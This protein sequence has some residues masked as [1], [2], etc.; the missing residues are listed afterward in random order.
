MG[1]S[2]GREAL[3]AQGGTPGEQGH[4]EPLGRPLHLSHH[5]KDGSV[6]PHW[7]EGPW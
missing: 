2:G 7:T 5:H 1:G 3:S 6:F 4:Q